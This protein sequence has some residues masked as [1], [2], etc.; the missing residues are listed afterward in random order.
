MINPG[1]QARNVLTFHVSLPYERYPEDRQVQA[2]CSQLLERLS[3]LHGIESAAV[4]SGL[5]LKDGLH[6]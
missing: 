4:S 1:F 3:K 6:V 5:P 2:F